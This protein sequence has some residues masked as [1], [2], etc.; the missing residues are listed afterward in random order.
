MER[1]G[2]VSRHLMA[3]A[4]SVRSVDTGDLGSTDHRKNIGIQYLQVVV[5]SMTNRATADYSTY[6]LRRGAGNLS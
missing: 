5:E 2:K 3:Y 1:D 6:S 4:N